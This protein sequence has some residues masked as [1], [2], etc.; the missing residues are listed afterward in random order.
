MLFWRDYKLTGQRVRYPIPCLQR[1]RT[2]CSIRL[3]IWRYGLHTIM[4][5]KSTNRST[6]P[7]PL[8]TRTS[9]DKGQNTHVHRGE[10]RLLF[11]YDECFADT[12]RGEYP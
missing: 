7:Y 2:Q 1:W 11:Y 10:H 9:S 3:A 4:R 12:Y 5:L 6:P 8:A